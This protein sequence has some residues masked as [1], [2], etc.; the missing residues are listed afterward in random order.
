M[1]HN[2]ST[3]R[4]DRTKMHFQQALIALTK[5]KGFHSVSVK[6][7]VEYAKY[8]R[9]TFYIHY[10]DK[11]ELA[12]DLL[13]TNF[14]LLEESFEKPY[15]F[16]REVSTDLLDHSFFHIISSIYNNREFYDLINY[17]DTIPKLHTRF[18]QIILKMYQEKFEFKTINDLPVNMDYFK[19]Y[20]AYGF[21]GL[22]AK[23]INTGFQTP[24][25]ELIK[26]IIMLTKTHMA[27]VKYIGKH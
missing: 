24:Q 14:N 27:S 4:K 23:W 7:I 3:P 17:V 5:E 1:Q 12:D 8:N 26:E 22:L 13:Y 15:R 6:D 16:K 18:P 9:S 2:S 25:E 10:Q 21:Y 19:R 20:T 11:F